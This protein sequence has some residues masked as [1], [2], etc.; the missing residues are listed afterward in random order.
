M[1]FLR[2]LTGSKYRITEQAVPLYIPSYR[3]TANKGTVIASASGRADSTNTALSTRTE[4]VDADDH[5]L[6]IEFTNT[7]ASSDHI[8]PDAGTNDIRYFPLFSVS[9]ALIFAAA[10][11]FVSREKRCPGN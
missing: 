10:F 7:Y 4:T 6:N 8:L 1:T 5:E 2:L 3:I 9:C 11:A